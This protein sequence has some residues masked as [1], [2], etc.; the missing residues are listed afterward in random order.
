MIV[1]T[2]ALVSLGIVVMLYLNADSVSALGAL[3]DCPPDVILSAVSTLLL[4]DNVGEVAP[5][6]MPV[7]QPKPCFEQ[8]SIELVGLVL[9]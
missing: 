9:R 7:L 4:V 3:R 2:S 5:G 6:L 1:S 8:Q